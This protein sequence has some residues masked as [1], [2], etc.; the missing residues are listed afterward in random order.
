MSSSPTPKKHLI[1][2]AVWTVASRWIIKGLGFVNTIIMARLLVPEDYGVVAIGTLFVGLIQTFL[3]FGATTALLRKHEVSRA[4]IDSAWTLRTIQ[5]LIAGALV[6]VATPL[7]AAYFHDPR[8]H[9]VLLVLGIGVILASISSIGQTLA[10]KEYNY[11]LDFKIVSIGK[12]A[13]VIVTICSGYFLRDYRALAL[14]IL[15]GYTVPLLLSYALHPYRP[16]WNTSEISAIWQ[17]TKWLM[18]SN[19]GTF[20]LRKGDELAASNLGSA[21]DYG[22]YNVGADL[23]QLPVGEVGPALMRALMPVLSSIQEDVERTCQAVTKSMAALNAI[24]WPIGLGTLALAPELTTA[25][26]GEKWLAAADYVAAFAVVGVLQNSVGPLRTILIVRGHTRPQ[27]HAVWIEFAV[28]VLA[29]IALEPIYDL[30]GLAYA[31]VISC[32]GSMIVTF[33]ASRHFC[34][35]PVR[36]TLAVMLR[37]AL[38]AVI[39]AMLVDAAINWAP[40]L[41]VKILAGVALGVVIY[42]I[43]CLLTWRLVGK[44]EGLESTVI[45]LFRAI[46]FKRKGG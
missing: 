9:F 41:S 1:R 32:V 19:I 42:P 39:M 16:R 12:L 11:A 29:A 5:G 2:G 15:A 30:I 20:V 43:W 36:E 46:S 33:A 23:G 34:H 45:D 17:I 27:S 22:L 24:I 37:P 44:P 8:L 18:L 7:L 28:F 35:Q 21:H 6:I 25:V 13:S 14:G 10:L 38:G 3:D 31:R 40:L 26:L 4:E